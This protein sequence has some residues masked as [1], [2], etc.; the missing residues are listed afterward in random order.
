MS[1]GAGPR[2]KLE[3][4]VDNM[5]LF[6]PDAHVSGSVKIG[7]LGDCVADRVGGCGGVCEG[8][9]GVVHVRD[10]DLLI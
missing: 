3:T 1:L 10:I 4:L 8:S 7:H 9:K 5:V 6:V 2:V